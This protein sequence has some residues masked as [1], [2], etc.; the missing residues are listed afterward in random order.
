MVKKALKLTLV[1][2]EGKKDFTAPF[3]SA[4]K[5]RATL[6]MQKKMES[7]GVG[8]GTIDEMAA[9]IVD[10][11]GGKFTEDELLDGIA[12]DEFLPTFTRCVETV[13]GNS[14]EKLSQFPEDAK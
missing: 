10:I 9:Y 1:I 11:F 5:L 14:N 4:R 12:G 2:G 7:E 3:I 8:E 13:T 6:S